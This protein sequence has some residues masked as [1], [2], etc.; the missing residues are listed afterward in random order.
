MN[1]AVR[2]VFV[3]MIELGLNVPSLFD[4]AGVIATGLLSNPGPSVTVKGAD[5]SATVPEL[6]PDRIY[7]VTAVQL[8]PP[9]SPGRDSSS[10]RN[11]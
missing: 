10:H 11:S 3:R 5:E 9:T 2:L 4:A 6:G 1:V 8:R 7:V